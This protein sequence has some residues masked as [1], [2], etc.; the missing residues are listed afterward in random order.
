MFNGN[1]YDTHK[2]VDRTITSGVAT[3]TAHIT[4]VRIR[5]AAKCYLYVGTFSTASSIDVLVAETSTTSSH[6]VYSRFVNSGSTLCAQNMVIPHGTHA[7]TYDLSDICGNSYMMVSAAC[8]PAD[9]CSLVLH[10]VR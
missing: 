10:Y 7:A 6:H 8:S 1:G 2:T 5:G 4:P 9:G 3:A